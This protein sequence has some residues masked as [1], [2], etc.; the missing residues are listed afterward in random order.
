MKADLHIHTNYSIDGM[1]SPKE[2]IDSAIKKDIKCICITDHGSVEGAIEAMK[3]A[4]SKDILVIPGIEVFSKSGDILG[5]NVKKIIPD[6]LSAEETIERIR[7]QNGLAVIPHPFGWSFMGFS[8]GRNKIQELRPDAFEVFNSSIGWTKGNKRALEFSKTDIP[9]TAGSD[10]HR[11]D[12]VGRGYM[13]ILDPVFSEKDVVQSI[14]EKRIKVGG[15]QL[16]IIEV[17]KNISM[18]KKNMKNIITRLFFEKFKNKK[19]LRAE[20]RIFEKGFS[21]Y[22][23]ILILAVI[24][25]IALGLSSLLIGQLK[26]MKTMEHSV[27]AFHAAEAGAE[28]ALYNIFQEEETL[29]D[30]YQ[31]TLGSN[32]SISTYTA[33]IFCCSSSLPGCEIECPSNLDVKEDCLATRYCIRSVGIHEGSRRTVE[34]KVEPLPL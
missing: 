22:F 33:Y 18:S 16:N 17:A 23:S 13:K 32:G 28:Q 27:A 9:F 30:K 3:I 10:A 19:C 2:I 14:L 7:R 25:A 12:F 5:I 11:A 21:L 20:E 1:S 26:M 29:E 15:T 31:G 24:L 34:V 4:F 8:G 6:N